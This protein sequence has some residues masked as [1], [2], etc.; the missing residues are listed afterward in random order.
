M[1]CIAFLVFIFIT[2]SNGECSRL[3]GK[4]AELQQ[5]DEFL[6][7]AEEIIEWKKVSEGDAENLFS[8][9]FLED[10]GASSVDW[11]AVALGRLGYPDNYN[12]YRSL[13]NSGK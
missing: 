3:C 12:A 10:A 2:F 9:P 5:T 1:L 8:F 13:F 4:R 6:E 11:H 7:I